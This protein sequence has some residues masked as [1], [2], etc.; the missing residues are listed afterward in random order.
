MRKTIR[1]TLQFAMGTSILWIIPLLAYISE[2]L[3]NFL[4]ENITIEQFI[5]ALTIIT[6]VGIM[7]LLTDL[8]REVK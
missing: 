5:Q 4:E 2:K 7:Y 3:Q 8:I 6:F 1:K